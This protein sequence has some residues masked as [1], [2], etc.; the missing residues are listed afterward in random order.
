MRL[1]RVWLLLALAAV[2]LLARPG[3]GDAAHMAAKSPSPTPTI[4]PLPTVKKGSVASVRYIRRGLSVTPP[5][6]PRQKGKVRM[7]LYSAYDL[8][9]AARQMASINFA[10]G[11][12][13]HMNQRTDAVLRSASVT[14]VKQGEIAQVVVPGTNHRVQ[15]AAAV[16][17]AVGTIFDV[18]YRKKI[19]TVIVIEGAVLV[20]DK[21]GSVVVKSGQE[22]TVKKGK[23]PSAPKIVDAAAAITWINP[24]PPAPGPPLMNIALDANGG[25]VVEASSQAAAPPPLRRHVHGEAAPATPWDAR[26]II[27]GRLDTGWSSA[28]GQSKA[29]WVKLAFA[30]LGTYPVTEVLID[31]AASGGHPAANDL[32]NF[33]IKVSTTGTDEASFQTVFRGSTAQQNTLQIFP[34]PANTTAKY[35]ELRAV[36]NYG[37]DAIDVAELEVVSAGPA[38]TLPTPTAT[39][40]STTTPT[41]KPSASPTVTPTVTPT[42]TP[43]ATPVPNATATATPIPYA[44][45]L[46]SDSSLIPAGAPANFHAAVSPAPADPSTILVLQEVRTASLRDQQTGGTPC[47]PGPACTIAV[48]KPNSAAGTYTYTAVLQRSD[49]TILARSATVTVIWTAF[50]IQSFTASATDVPLGTPVHF[51]GVL[52]QPLGTSTYRAVVA[53]L[54]TQNSL[55]TTCSGTTCGADAQ[56]NVPGSYVFIFALVDTSGNVVVQSNQLTVYWQWQIDLS[57]DHTT[58]PV[59]T[60]VNLTATANASV[61]NSGYD[62]VIASST[63]NSA[64]CTSGSTCTWQVYSNTAGSVQFQAYIVDAN[65]NAVVSSAVV[66]IT[67][68]QSWSI[69]LSAKPTN[70]AYQAT[71]TLTAVASQ[72]VSSAGYHILIEDA[73]NGYVYNQ[74]SSGTVCSADVPY[75]DAAGGTG[76]QT[77][78]YGSCDYVAIISDGQNVIAQSSVVTITWQAGLVARDAGS[79][80]SAHAH[81]LQPAKRHRLAPPA[82]TRAAPPPPP[83]LGLVWRARPGRIV[84]PLPA[85]LVPPWM[86]GVSA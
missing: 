79:V 25:T 51:T 3:A 59:G 34:L 48:T 56:A 62:I 21:K 19:M 20:S 44:V 43:T 23:A 10:D 46:T 64:S 5:H 4:P 9:T 30:N 82:Q 71:S 69:T 60:T 75:T 29:Q 80:R 55:Q 32:D 84:S 28:S 18:R 72:D 22:T 78:G 1:I 61:T 67:W 11:T 36:D 7:S 47:P 77:Q 37:G 76:C 57:A 38:L 6:K 50:S 33:T 27:D 12:L 86:P 35:I 31:P 26:N 70:P 65:N 52:N 40:T 53:E 42:P 73:H 58:V 8:Q 54:R 39:P 66:T 17:S 49:G 13:L 83:G 41:P 45:T 24:I 63:Q 68:Q 85:S 81:R 2:C 74:C 14:A 15:T 16:A